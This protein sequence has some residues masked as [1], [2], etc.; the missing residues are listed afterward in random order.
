[1]TKPFV[2]KSSR[3]VA[4]VITKYIPYSDVA[5]NTATSHATLSLHPCHWQWDPNPIYIIPYKTQ[6]LTWAAT[7]RTTLCLALLLYPGALGFGVYLMNSASLRVCSPIDVGVA[8]VTL[9]P[10][11]CEKYIASFWKR[12]DRNPPGVRTAGTRGWCWGTS[13]ISR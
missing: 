12:K 5:H 8:E 11:N 3:R 10:I 2:T 6:T 7:I 9:A 4:T 1:M 13:T